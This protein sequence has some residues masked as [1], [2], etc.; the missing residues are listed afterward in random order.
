MR[1]RASPSPPSKVTDAQLTKMSEAQIADSAAEHQ[2]WLDRL[3]SQ[4]D[5]GAGKPATEAEAAREK[6]LKSIETVASC[7]VP[8]LRA[9]QRRICTHGPSGSGTMQ[10]LPPR[11]P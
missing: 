10:A 1:R 11:R 6:H 9:I 5:P 4:P 2:Q 8:W 7:R 3:A